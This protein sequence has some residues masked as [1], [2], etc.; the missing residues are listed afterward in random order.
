[1]AEEDGGWFWLRGLG[2]GTQET[3]IN[4]KL[5]SMCVL[6]VRVLE[7][8]TQG[9]APTVLGSLSPLVH[10]AWCWLTVGSGEYTFKG[11]NC[12]SLDCDAAQELNVNPVILCCFFL[13]N[14]TTTEKAITVY[15]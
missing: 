10:R 14:S 11:R 6:W 5:L 12:F 3:A 8:R 15:N 1:M 2:G 13:F 7:L 4:S 9:A